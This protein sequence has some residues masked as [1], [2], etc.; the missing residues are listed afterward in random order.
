[1]NPAN[2]SQ[3]LAAT[4]IYTGTDSQ[5]GE[6]GIYCSDD[7][8]A[9]WILLN[10]HP[11]EAGGAAGTSVFYASGTIAYAALGR[12]TGDPQNGI[13]FSANAGAACASQ[14]WAAVTGAG[15]PAQSS[16]G[17]IA[18]TSAPNVA[19]NPG[20]RTRRK[21]FCTQ[22]SRVRVPRR[23]IHWEFFAAWMAAPLG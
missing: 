21:L 11:A 5:P 16:V 10:L 7:Q 4:Q 13:Y 17:H 18:L 2:S 8:G 15:L 23:K 6:P 19:N 20:M 22:K 14:T 1:M 3:L 9:T 12:T